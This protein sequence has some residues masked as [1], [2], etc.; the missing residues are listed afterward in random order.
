[1]TLHVPIEGATP[2]TEG[3]TQGGRTKEEERRAAWAFVRGDTQSEG[4]EGGE[5]DPFGTD[6][7]K[8]VEGGG[9]GCKS[10][11]D[12]DDGDDDDD[13]E[14]DDEEDDTAEPLLECHR[15]CALAYRRCT[16]SLA[17]ASCLSGSCA[18]EV[19]LCGD[20]APP[21]RSLSSC[22]SFEG[23]APPQAAGSG[24]AV[25]MGPAWAASEGKGGREEEERTRGVLI[26]YALRMVARRL[27]AAL[28]V[29]AL[30]R[31]F[32][33]LPS[34]SGLFGAPSMR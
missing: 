8:I 22:S 9:D 17:Q 16:R 26:V 34:L 14:E 6:E 10:D 11:D 32:G 27:G 12:D 31:A 19:P 29:Y 30:S 15:R 3:G 24:G 23:A 7:E 25:P 33:A 21:H 2:A 13:D 28:A 20:S 5:D 4:G 18:C 1:M